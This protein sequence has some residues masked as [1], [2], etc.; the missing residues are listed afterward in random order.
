MSPARFFR[1]LVENPDIPDAGDAAGIVSALCPSPCPARQIAW[2]SHDVGNRGSRPLRSPAPSAT[3]AACVPA[4]ESGS[5][6]LR[7]KPPHFLADSSTD[8][9]YPVLSLQKMD[10][11]RA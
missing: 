8:L 5:F 7:T 1:S 4:L 11:W 2:W 9:Q 6:H 10:R 3:S